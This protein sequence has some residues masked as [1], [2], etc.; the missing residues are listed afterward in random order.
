MVDEDFTPTI[1]YDVR[2]NPLVGPVA[3]HVHNAQNG[4]LDTP[5]GN[6]SDPL[7]RA[8]DPA[9][10]TANRNAACGKVKVPSGDSCDEFPLASSY[11]GAA[12]Q[13]DFSTAVV[14]SSA[15]NS[16]GGI[17]S[18]FYT[19]NRVVDDDAFYVLA[20]LSTGATSW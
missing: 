2:Q 10:I 6:P 7:R 4:D 18:N 15:N 13:D 19:G 14:P 12:F 1:A 17:T 11:Q 16:Q 5:W 20:V 8:T 9:D 3:Q